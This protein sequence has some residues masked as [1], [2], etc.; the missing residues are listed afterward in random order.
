MDI[1]ID[2]PTSFD[3]TS[4]FKEAVRASQVRDNE[5]TPHPCGVYFQ[6][7]PTDGLTGLAA[8]PYD[9][10][11]ELGYL[12]VD[13]LH[14]T[15]LNHFKS[16]DEIRQ[17]ISQEPDWTLL[18]KRDNVEKLFQ[19]HKH[20]D[21]VSQV[22]PRS[23]QEI[24]DCIALIRPGKKHLLEEY[25]VDRETTRKELYRKAEDGY[26]FK[27]SHAISYALTIILQLHLIKRNVL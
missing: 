27:K 18:N 16:K 4:V 15:V 3:P 20:Y 22:N 8:I 11:E 23:V 5:L 10:A 13:M 7:I 14:L 24:A 2:F 25:L 19:L 9:K 21:L 12:K 1:D 26:S 17:L 6:T